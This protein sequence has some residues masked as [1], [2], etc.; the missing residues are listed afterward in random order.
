[1]ATIFKL[2]QLAKVFI[3]GGPIFNSNTQAVAGGLSKGDPYIQDS[4]SISYL[5]VVK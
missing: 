4:G 2:I 1:M 5:C 3:S